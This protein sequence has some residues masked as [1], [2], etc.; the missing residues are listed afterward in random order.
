MDKEYGIILIDPPYPDLTI[1]NIIAELS[2]LRLVGVNTMVVVT[3]SPHHPLAGVYGTL[4]RVKENRHG[5][6]CIAIYRK[7]AQI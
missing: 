2:Q 4:R 6:S 7:E 1:G 5:D 3:H